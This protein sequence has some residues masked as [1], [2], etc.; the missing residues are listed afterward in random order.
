MKTKNQPTESCI[1]IVGRIKA[2]LEDH[3]GCAMSIGLTQALIKDC[4]EVLK[5]LKTGA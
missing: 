5:R 3:Q 2:N 4:A 1:E